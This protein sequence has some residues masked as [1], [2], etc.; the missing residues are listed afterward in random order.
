[1][2]PSRSRFQAATEPLPAVSA[3]ISRERR[4]LLTALACVAVSAGLGYAIGQGDGVNADDARRD[5]TRAGERAGR[6]AGDRAGYKEG[7]AEG[8]REGYRRAYTP[9]YREAYRKAKA[10]L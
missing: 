4:W 9:A 3:P 5:G 10:G 8:S 7:F 2:D 6:N 1:M